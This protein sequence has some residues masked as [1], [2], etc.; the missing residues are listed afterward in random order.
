MKR[1]LTILAVFLCTVV[2][3]RERKA[4]Y[5][6]DGKVQYEY[7]M[8]G[9]LFDGRFT[10]YYETGKLRMK[11]QFLNNQKTG[12]WRVWD[13]KGYLRSE[14]NYTNNLVFTIVNEYDS[15]GTKLRQMTAEQRSSLSCGF[16]DYMFSNKYISRIDKEDAI[17]AELFAEDGLVATLFCNASTGNTAIFSEDRFITTVKKSALASYQPSDI[18]SVLVKEVYYCCFKDQAMNNQ[19]LGICPVVMEDGKPKELGWFHVPEISFKQDILRKI[20]NHEYLSTIIKTSV[21]DPSSKL[22]EV[23]ER[24]N[25]LLRIMLVE[26]EASAILYT[27]DNQMLANL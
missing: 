14:R 6:P 7:E 9:H 4:I 21:K 13:E 16:R 23:G 12:L 11:G 19:V 8:E 10:C 26:F 17:N 3:A 22:R 18:V 20:S 25:D 1:T 27:M 15:S 24:E 5:Y 2:N